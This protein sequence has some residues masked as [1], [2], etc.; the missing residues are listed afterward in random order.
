MKE[1][2]ERRPV[3]RGP[4]RAPDGYD[5]IMQY[6]DPV[7]KMDAWVGYRIAFCRCLLNWPEGIVGSDI[8]RGLYPSRP[9]DIL[10]FEV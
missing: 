5:G 9:A 1:P 2:K 10:A 4:N 8:W 7:L 3:S 6:R